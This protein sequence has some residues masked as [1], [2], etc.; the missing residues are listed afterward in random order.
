P[1][2]T[3]GQPRDPFGAVGVSDTALIEQSRW[4]RSDFAVRDDLRLLEQ[5]EQSPFSLEVHAPSTI[6]RGRLVAGE[7][8][9]EDYP[10][11]CV[12]RSAA[13]GPDG[14]LDPLLPFE[15][16]WEVSRVLDDGAEQVVS[17][18]S[19]IGA[20]HRD[21]P[22]AHIR[23]L[24]SALL[25]EGYVEYASLL[26]LFRNTV[27]PANIQVGTYRLRAQP[28]VLRS[29]ASP[30]ELQTAPLLF[31]IQVVRHQDDTTPDR[32]GSTESFNGGQFP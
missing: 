31:D 2:P 16:G 5:I 18:E 23:Q 1:S 10:I 30:L 17:E 21:P 26:G 19:F 12:A 3:V 22:G 20:F 6:P 9:F 13:G 32:A 28:V 7:V 25:V 8:R 11:V 24:P 4:Q 27:H 14:V 29:A 15:E